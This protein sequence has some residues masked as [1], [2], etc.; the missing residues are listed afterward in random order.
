MLLTF[1]LIAA[2]SLMALYFVSQF[3][4]TFPLRLIFHAALTG[5]IILSEFWINVAVDPRRR[6]L[7]LGIYTTML[8]LGFV[9]GP[10]TSDNRF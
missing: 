3:T 6:G 4:A 8:S 5:I 1:L 2:A 9:A 10:L 7:F